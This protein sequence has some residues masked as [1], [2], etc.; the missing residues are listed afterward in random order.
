[1]NIKY[2]LRQLTMPGLLLNNIKY[3][4]STP[5]PV[6]S[7]APL[8]LTLWICNRCNLKCGFCLK[9]IDGL[10][11]RRQILPDMTLDTFKK[12]LALFKTASSISFISDGEPLLNKDFLDM[13]DYTLK[14]KKRISSVSLVT[15]GTLIDGAMAE[16]LILSNLSS[17]EIS[18]K[19]ASPEEFQKVTKSSK[20]YY[21]RVIDGIKCLVALRKNLKV[22][23]KIG[24]SYVLYKSRLAQMPEAIEL[25]SSL[26]VDYL[27]FHNFVPYGK[28]D[29]EGAKEVL[30]CDDQEVAMFIQ[31]L[32]KIPQKI[33]IRW[34]LLLRKNNYS[35][36]CHSLFHTLIIDSMG[37]VGMC[38][39]ALPPPS[40]EYGNIFKDK[41][42][43]NSKHFVE[44]RRCFLSQQKNKRDE[45]PNGCKFCTEMS[46]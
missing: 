23:K 6:L 46:M 34:P 21:D 2:W 22:D 1:M 15:N 13:V 25:A 29:S 44:M 16:K 30:F 18:L 17:I 10:W 45:L 27:L 7:Y 3:K 28:F 33:E 43:W 4:F 39:L 42:I 11:N 36:Y 41:N 19:A 12:I 40:S 20:I 26:N 24:L 38:G 9:N 32:K 37:H 14:F 35:G 31:K 8:S 5:Q